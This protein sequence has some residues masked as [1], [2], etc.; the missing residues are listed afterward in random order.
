TRN[1]TINSRG[2]P[3]WLKRHNPPPGAPPPA[4][5]PP[6]PAPQRR[7]PP[8]PPAI[9]NANLLT[10]QPSAP[11]QPT[12]S[13]STT[14]A[15]GV[16]WAGYVEDWRHRV[17]EI[18]NRNYPAEVRQQNLFGSLELQVTIR[19]DGALLDVSVR[20]SSG[21]SVLDQAAMRI[22]RQ[23]APYPPFPSKLA[24]EYGSLQV[25]RKWTFTTAN[26]LAGS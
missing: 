22:V 26:Q 25:V 15:V 12:P 18:G 5:P 3:R 23:A 9:A 1:P 2:R 17:E 19:A 24:A 11:P 14:A 6:P 20:R 10:T 8:P 21:S 13:T 16:S 7:H 4:A